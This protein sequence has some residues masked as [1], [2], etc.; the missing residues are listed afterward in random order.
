MGGLARIGCLDGKSL[1]LD[2]AGGLAGDVVD[3]AVDA[4]DL[5]DD[6]AADALEHLVGQRGPVGGHAVFRMHGAH[7]G[8]VGVGA[9]VA[10]HA[11]AHHRQQHG[12]ALPDRVSR[13]RRP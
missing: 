2:G 12:K 3:H 5:V 6:A 7:G 11:H 8:G 4:A 9:L 10:H 1:P 13:A